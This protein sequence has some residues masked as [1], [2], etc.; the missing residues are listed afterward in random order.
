LVLGYFISPFPCLAHQLRQPLWVPSDEEV[1]RPILC[2]PGPHSSQVGPS[3]SS[4]LPPPDYSDLQDN[5][6]SIQEE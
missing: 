4:Q 1:V 6:T 5:V 3:S 2:H